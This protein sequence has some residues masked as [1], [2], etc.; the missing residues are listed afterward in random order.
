MRPADS[1]PAAHHPAALRKALTQLCEGLQWIE[2]PFIPPEG[3]DGSEPDMGDEV[4]ELLATDRYGVF[5][6]YGD[7]SLVLPGWAWSPG[8]LRQLAQMQHALA[9]RGIRPTDPGD[10][11]D[12][13]VQLAT[14]TDALLGAAIEAGPLLRALRATALA[15]HSDEHASAAWPWEEVWVSSI[16]MPQ[17]LRMPQPGGAGSPRRGRCAALNIPSDLSQ[18]RSCEIVLC[19]FVISMALPC[20]YLYTQLTRLIN[21]SYPLKL[22]ER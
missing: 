3:W 18:V 2:Q 7:P 14:V 21:R 12:T 4:K 19:Y 20:T 8:M 1:L 15:L 16:D 22:H 9:E 10:L 17:L 13:T 11:W 5:G 6:S